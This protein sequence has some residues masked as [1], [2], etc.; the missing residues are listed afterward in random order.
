MV[1]SSPYWFALLTLSVVNAF[2]DTIVRISGND[3]HF[4]SS[5]GLANS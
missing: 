2:I 1:K 4:K 5:K 3:Q